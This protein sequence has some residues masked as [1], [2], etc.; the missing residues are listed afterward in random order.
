MLRSLL[1]LDA[2][3]AWTRPAWGW[4]GELALVAL[5]I[6]LAADRL[7]DRIGSALAGLDVAWPDP[8]L[9]LQAGIWLAV[10]VE[11]WA[12][13]WAG[14][15]LAQAGGVP[16]ARPRAWWERRSL[17]AVVVPVFWAPVAAAG[18]FAVMLAVEDAV[19]PFLLGHAA[20]FALAMAA[21]VGWRYGLAGLERVIRRMEAPERWW[22][23]LPGAL[24]ALPLAWLAIRHGLPVWGSP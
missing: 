9:P 11:I 23:S 6:H 24:V 2:A 4:L 13:A 5:G 17:A 21:L 19:A 16:V 7:D 1:K 22:A 3:V 20:A 14:R 18:T 8:D 10:A 15:W 12:V